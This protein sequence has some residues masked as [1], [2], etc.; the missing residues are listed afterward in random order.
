[1]KE[2]KTLNVLV[3]VV[4]Q[5]KSDVQNFGHEGR[6][7][8]LVHPLVANSDLLIKNA[9]ERALSVIAVRNFKKVR[10]RESIF[11]QSSRFT[12]CKVRDR[13]LVAQSLMAFNLRKVIHPT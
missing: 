6:E 3:R 9:I 13:K 4:I 10:E 1:M 7:F 11:F 2:R 5:K 8:V 12:A